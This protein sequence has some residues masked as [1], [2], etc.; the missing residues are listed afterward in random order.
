MPY[1]T[2]SGQPPT[3]PQPPARGRIRLPA[4]R[5]DGRVIAERLTPEQRRELGVGPDPTPEDEQCGTGDDAY[6]AWQREK[7]AERNAMG[8]WAMG[9]RRRQMA[10]EMRD[11]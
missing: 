7:Q 10:Q 1:R 11:E 8:Q 3:G 5:A 4:L 9:D 2:Q 6:L